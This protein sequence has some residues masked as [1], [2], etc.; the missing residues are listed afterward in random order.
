MLKRVWSKDQSDIKSSVATVGMS[1]GK[2]YIVQ[3][4]V[5]YPETWDL[6]SVEIAAS[7]YFRKSGIGESGK[8]GENSVFDL[9]K[10]IALCLRLR[11]SSRG[12][13]SS[14]EEA[15]IFEDEI[16]CGF[17]RQKIG[18]N[19]PVNFNFG[20]YDYY[21]IKG[22]SNRKRYFVNPETQQVDSVDY[23]LIRPGGAACFLSGVSDSLIDEKETGMF[24]LLTNQMKIF[25]TGAGDGVNISNIRGKDEPISGGGI[26]SGILPYLKVRDAASGYIRSGGKTRRSA[27]LLCL[28][29]DHPDL[30]D[31]IEWKVTEEEKAYALIN[32]GYSSGMEGDAYSTVSGQNSN[33]SIR[34][35][36]AFM[37]ALENGMDWCLISRQPYSSFHGASENGLVF[38]ETTSQGDIYSDSTGERIAIKKN[39][40]DV[41]RKIMGVYSAE[42][43]WEKICSSAWRCGCPAVQFDDIINEWNS[44][45]H[46]GKINTTNPCSEICLPDWSVCNLGSINLT[47]VFSNLNDANVFGEELKEFDHAVNLMTIALDLVV[48]VSSYPTQQHAEGSWKLRSIGLNHGGIGALLM[49]SGIPYDSEIGRSYM[50]FITSYMTARSI[51]TSAELAEKMGPYP[52]FDYDNHQR[53]LQKHADALLEIKDSFVHKKLFSSLKK[54]WS[55]IIGSEGIKE[56]GLRNNTHTTLVPQGTI[57]IVLGQDTYGCEPDFSLKR[58]KKLIGGGS[59]VFVN[60]AVKKGLEVL[61]YS[62]EDIEKCLKYVDKWATLEGCPV[63]SEKDV[64]VFDTANCPPSSFDFGGGFSV[65]EDVKSKIL[66]AVRENCSQVDGEKVIYKKLKEFLSPEKYADA[67]ANKRVKIFKRFISIDG[68][69]DALAAFQP[70]ISHSISKTCNMPKDSSVEEIGNAYRYAF[71][72]GV[73]CVAIYRDES[74]GSQPLSSY[75]EDAEAN[76]AQRDDEYVKIQELIE[77]K[78]KGEWHPDMDGLFWPAIK[79]PRAYL[80]Q[81]GLH[82]EFNMRDPSTGEKKNIYLGMPF[83]PGTKDLM[84]L[85]INTGAQGETVTGLCESLG[86]VISVALQHG[87]PPERIGSTL[88]DSRFSPGGW[89]DK[90][91]FGIVKAQ[92][93]PDLVGQALLRY[94]NS[95]EVAGDVPD[96]EKGSLGELEGVMEK[97]V[98]VLSDWDQVVRQK[99]EAKAKGF[100]GKRCEMCGGWNVTGSGRCWLCE[101]CGHS[102]GVCG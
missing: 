71:A 84:A 8:E 56:H 40:E 95:Q 83:Y 59:M 97:D 93:I 13:F 38:S 34:I 74:K 26:S 63:I 16:R 68:H 70:H 35:S 60:R 79:K 25:V 19:S 75:D 18:F 3:Q 1:E 53:I 17:L 33:N 44:V 101:D 41:L 46:Y 37:E 30:I 45:P 100:V 88:K 69:I 4:G 64:A 58:Y 23:E 85:F 72:K 87:I 6:N 96:I 15:D 78:K 29:D 42:F 81:D 20:L 49:Q 67:V 51:K 76:V 2:K 28:N 80:S 47:K 14:E 48:D 12:Y 61:G 82:L 86:K 65:D 57:G 91:H 54:T 21:G 22:D 9:A 62:P 73:K 31:F 27:T 89:I 99:Q 50:S 36:N 98:V 92:S 11:G 90:H 52:V 66:N 5:A 7:K 77:M 94:R 10:R 102:S 32:S 24:D 43:I 39:G 55:E